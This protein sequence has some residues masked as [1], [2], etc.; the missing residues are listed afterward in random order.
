MDHIADGHVEI[1]VAGTPVADTGVG[2]VIKDL[3]GRDNNVIHPNDKLPN[4]PQ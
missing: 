1:R 3:L 4:V 2:V